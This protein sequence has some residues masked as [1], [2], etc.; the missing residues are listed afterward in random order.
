MENILKNSWQYIMLIIL[1]IKKDYLEKNTIYFIDNKK[2]LTK[3]IKLSNIFKENIY[4][5]EYIIIPYKLI[6]KSFEFY[7]YNKGYKVCLYL[8]KQIINAGYFI[9]DIY[10]L[11]KKFFGNCVIWNQNKKNLSKKPAIVQTIADGPKDVY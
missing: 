3:T 11:N 6:Y 9:N 4:I 2:R 8:I 1:K 7:H 5:N 10:R